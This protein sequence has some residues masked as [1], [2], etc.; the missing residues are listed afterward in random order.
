MTLQPQRTIDELKEL[1]VG[2]SRLTL[3]LV[4]EIAL[5][6]HLILQPRRSAASTKPP[7]VVTNQ[8]V[9]CR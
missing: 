9:L 1:Q 4:V 7:I 2:F 8:S 3:G 5:S 6:F